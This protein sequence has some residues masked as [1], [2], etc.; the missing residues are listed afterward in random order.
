MAGVTRATSRLLR[1]SRVN[2]GRPDVAEQRHA[3]Y[4][5]RSQNP[6]SEDLVKQQSATRRSVLA[7]AAAALGGFALPFPVAG[8]SPR[9]PFSSPRHELLA[10]QRIVGST[11]PGTVWWWHFGEISLCVPRRGIFPVARVQTIAFSRT[12]WLGPESC[13]THFTEVGCLLDLEADELI[14][15]WRNPLTGVLSTGAS[16]SLAGTTFVEGPGMLE[17]AVVNGRLV[18]NTE[19]NRNKMQDLAAQWDI[20]GS[21]VTCTTIQESAAMVIVQSSHADASALEEYGPDSIEATQHYTMIHAASAVG[22][23]AKVEDAEALVLVRGYSR[24]AP[25]S[26]MVDPAMYERL[27]AQHPLQVPGVSAHE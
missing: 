16:G 17:L 3:R 18:G 9:R 10:Y 27:R 6:V 14:S 12:E 23:W 15:R 5:L 8:T 19:I 21:H 11:R 13:R 26:V 24:K 7:G 4:T 20:A 25:E 2:S 1:F 22:D